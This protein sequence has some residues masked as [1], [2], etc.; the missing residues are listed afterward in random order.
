[1][2]KKE[3]ITLEKHFRDYNKGFNFLKIVAL[4]ITSISIIGAL[5]FG[6]YSINII[7]DLRGKVLVMD[8]DGGLHY[9]K[10]Y[11]LDKL[12]DVEYKKAVKDF[13]SLWFEHNEKSFRKRLSQ[14]L[15]LVGDCGKDLVL[16]YE[17]EERLKIL[18]KYGLDITFGVKDVKIDMTTYPAGGIMEGVQIIN[19]GKGT[20]KKAVKAQFTIK[21]Y[22]ERTDDN[23]HA[24]Q[25]NDFKYIEKVIG[26]N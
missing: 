4:T 20:I 19:D 16:R 12:R 11:Q 1:M 9:T 18:K 7:N 13:S 22:G 17:K 14:G 24:V 15:E 10:A 23:P 21:D 3:E 26:N 5:G 6:I 2:E 25:I 8:W